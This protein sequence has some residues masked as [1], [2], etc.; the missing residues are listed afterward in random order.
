MPET[1]L[2]A[3]LGGRVQLR[4]LRAGHRAGL[5]AALLAAAAGDPVERF[6]DVGAGV[7]AVA[8][9]LLARWPEAQADL[10]EIDAAAAALARENLETNGVAD[11]GRVAEADLLSPPSRRAAGLGDEGADLVV[12]NPPFYATGSVRASPVK[13]K[14]GA[15]VF[16]AQEGDPLAAWIRACLAL[17]K[18]DGRFVMIHRADA[19]GALLQG[20]GARLGDIAV[21]PVHPRAEAEAIRVLVSGVK[22][23]KAPLRLLP[24]LT[25]HE[26]GGAYTARAEAALRGELLL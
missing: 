18:P 3:F 4:Q 19:L 24:G 25:L 12:S 16:S 8:L 21:R 2:D 15:H 5:D 17:L 14:A 13:A 20:I 7:G 10:V 22:G 9:S 11:R 26:A 1:S 23:S 6:V